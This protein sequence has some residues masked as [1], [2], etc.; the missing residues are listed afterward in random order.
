M[1]PREA[2]Q[3]LVAERVGRTVATASTAPVAASS[4]GGGVRVAVGVDADDVVDAL[5]E[6]AHARPPER[7]GVLVVGLDRRAA[8]L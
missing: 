2:Q 6:H 4:D 1:Q 5:C 3:A 8:R 7:S